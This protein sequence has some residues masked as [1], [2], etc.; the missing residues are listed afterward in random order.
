MIGQHRS[1]TLLGLKSRWTLG[2]VLGPA[3]LA[4]LHADGVQ[5]AADDVVADAREVLHAAPADH[6]HRVLLEVVA[7]ARDV[8]GYLD[9]VGEAHARHLAQGGVRLLRRRGVDA[10]ADP[11]LLGALLEGGALALELQLLATN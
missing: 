2:A 6:H 3:L 5:R 4:A 7:H 11:P 8:R 10:S 1:N 9:P